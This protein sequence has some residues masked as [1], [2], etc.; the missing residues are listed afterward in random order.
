MEE[1]GLEGCHGVV[2]ISV[3]A[4]GPNGRGYKPGRDDGFLRAIKIPEHLP[5]VG[6]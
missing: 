2:V 1:Y 6:R 3:L 4:T 5:S